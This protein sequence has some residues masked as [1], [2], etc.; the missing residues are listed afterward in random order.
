MADN[1]VPNYPDI[2]GYIT[3]G[4]RLTIANEVEVAVAAHPQVVRAGRPFEVIAVMQNITDVNL[5]VIAVLQLPKK[6]VKNT[7]DR[8]L[9]KNDRLSI[10]VQ[11][12]ETG[13]LI[14][15]VWSH[16][17]TAPGDYPI[18]VELEVK[19][20]DK[21]RRIRQKPE[22]DLAVNL[23]YYFSL[24]EESAEQL[25]SLKSLT[26]SS[27]K[28]GL[29]GK[30]IETTVRVGPGKGSKPLRSNPEWISL[31]SLGTDTDVR[32]LLERYHTLLAQKVLPTLT[33]AHLYDALH[34][35]T[36]DR[37]FIAGYPAREVEVHYIVKLMIA[38]LE[39]GRQPHGP[40]AYPGENMYRVAGL[41]QNG[42][43][44]DGRPI[45]LPHWC[46]RLL[47]TIGFDDRVLENPIEALSRPLYEELLRDAVWYGFK[48]LRSATGVDLGDDQ[49]MRA[50]AEQIIKALWEP[51]VSLDFI[52]VHMPMVFGGLLVDDRVKMASEDRFNN[53]HELLEMYESREDQYG[54]DMSI[55]FD[56]ALHLVDTALQKHG[57]W[58]G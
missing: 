55:F 46:R 27:E 37:L 45:P 5:Q 24:S 56:L 54:E 11:P 35:S 15:P 34:R 7:S 23:Q 1:N 39:M 49:D 48:L 21:P 12:A 53:F 25:A 51:D 58:T 32:P 6:D 52:D 9:T 8:F 29:F 2:L 28:R 47:F 19:S 13:Y 10:T 26:F 41:L 38:V 50:Y 4:D 31:W 44:T 16:P 40:E 36:R 20:L 30:G 57:F 14:L 17:D 33:V 42:W 43:P 22:S 18:G 3:G